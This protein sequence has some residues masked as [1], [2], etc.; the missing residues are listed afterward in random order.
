MKFLD[1][2]KI[3]LKAGDGGSGS[4]SFRREKFVEFGGPDG[5]DGGNGGSII[6]IAE[7]NLN[8]LV[9][10]RYQ[11]HFKAERGQNGSG[12]KKTGR[13]GKDL[14]LKVPVGTQIL[15]ED[16]NT[17]IADLTK[18]EQEIIV[19][20]GGKGGLGNVRFKSSINRAP[21]K[22]TGGREGEYLWIW[23]Q[24]K[25]I[26]DIGIVG[27][28]NSGK[29]SLLSV[30]TSAKPKIANYPFTT[31]NPNLGV[32]SYDNKEITL[33]DIPGL[34]E[35]AH[36]GVGLG[37][38]FL[39]HIERCK[40]LLHLIDI[41]NEN[42]LENYSKVRK[43]LSKYSKKL[44]KKKE[45]IV[46]NKIDMIEEESSIKKINILKKKLKKDVYAIS[47]IEKKGIQNIKKILINHV[48]K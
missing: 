1:Q 14:I 7:R 9:D 3:Y 42:V 32:T 30:I 23:L 28:P 36:E 27:M 46:L 15:E 44:I 16:N 10:F 11:Q 19:A 4:A 8:T 41:T 6:F 48:H 18:H 26:A 5:G 40:N 17:L 13:S 25:V 45:I 22:K 2:S 12:K 24:L 43:E 37:D 21:R 31:I 20:Y 34:I 33:A 29:S 39:R 38:K 47:V 35:G